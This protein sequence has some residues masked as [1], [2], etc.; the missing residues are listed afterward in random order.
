[1]KRA[2]VAPAARLRIT[3]KAASRQL[4]ERLQRSPVDRSSLRNFQTQDRSVEHQGKVVIMRSRQALCIHHRLKRVDLDSCGSGSLCSGGANPSPNAS[5]DQSGGSSGEQ[6]G[7]AHRICC[8]RSAL[9]CGSVLLRYRGHA[10]SGQKVDAWT[11]K[12]L[13]EPCRRGAL[14]R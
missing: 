12:V 3:A 1:M 13:A 14:A 6:I 7:L 10:Q 2:A 4:S 9:C 8:W 11:C 5:K